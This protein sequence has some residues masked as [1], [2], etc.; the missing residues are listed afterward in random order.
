[1]LMR[2]AV[3]Q[4]VHHCTYREAFGGKL[5][6]KPLM[7]NVLA[8]LALESE[9]ATTLALRLA[10][11]YDDGSERER[12]LLRIAVPAAEYWVTKRCAPLAVEAAEC[13]GGNGY[14]E[15]SG[16]PRLV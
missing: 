14:V 11:A 15:E 2:Q 4:A 3:A 8:D 9:A 12:A 7:R 10:A 1:G 13:L 5:I 16:M 6:D